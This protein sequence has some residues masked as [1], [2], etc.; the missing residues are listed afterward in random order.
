[1]QSSTVLQ[2][3]VCVCV[4][5]C[6]PHGS[7]SWSPGTMKTRSENLTHLLVCSNTNGVLH[8]F[9]TSSM[10][11]V[12]GRVAAQTHRNF[13]KK[14]TATQHDEK[15]TSTSTSGR[16]GAARGRTKHK[17][18]RAQKNACVTGRHTHTYCTNARSSRCRSYANTRTHLL[19][20]HT[21]YIANGNGYGL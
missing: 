15:N 20:A 11:T 4:C 5:R 18:M 21:L 16:S 13:H 7:N 10:P 17:R 8:N 6:W 9:S 3:K 2:Y 19:S 14:E 1:M 12:V